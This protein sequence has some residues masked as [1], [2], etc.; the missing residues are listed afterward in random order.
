MTGM[1][2]A[3]VGIAVLAWVIVN[4]LRPQPLTARRLRLAG[5]LAVVG[6]V[7]L[8]SAAGAHPV[9]PMGWTL[10][11]LGLAI[12]AVLGALRARTVRLW[13]RDG[14]VWTQGHALTAVLWVVGIGAHVG[15][16]LLARTVVP[17]A[18]TV[19]TASILLFVAV[20]LGV[21]G[22]VTVQRTRGLAGA[23]SVQPV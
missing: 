23:R 13:V 8:V 16:D 10:L 21:Q 4:Q 7:Q 18:E 19:N 22:L 2:S 20:S 12:G 6:V 15:L 5:I 17:A 11:A 3:L 9:P 14:V 1:L